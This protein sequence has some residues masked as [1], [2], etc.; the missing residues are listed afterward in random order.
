MFRDWKNRRSCA[1]ASR[2]KGAGPLD[3]CFRV[4]LIVLRQNKMPHVDSFD[5]SSGIAV[6]VQQGVSVLGILEK[7][8]FSE[9]QMPASEG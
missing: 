4:F 6:D 9:F 2:R 5:L 1:A 3:P 8:D 7:K